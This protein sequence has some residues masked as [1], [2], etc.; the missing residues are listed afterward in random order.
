MKHAEMLPE[1]VDMSI[2]AAPP[3]AVTGMSVFGVQLP[4][5][6]SIA[7]LIY[8]AIHGGYILTKWMRGK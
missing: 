4:D 5:I 8:L 1:I 3:L 6:V 2:K 7:T